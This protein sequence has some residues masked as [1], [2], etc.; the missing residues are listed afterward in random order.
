MNETTEYPA[1]TVFSCAGKDAFTEYKNTPINP[2]ISL[3]GA[4]AI[5]TG[6]YENAPN[7]Q[8]LTQSEAELLMQT[9]KWI[10]PED[11]HDDVSESL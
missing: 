1:Y 8:F 3:D 10:A 6:I 2:R 4:Q 11:N 7:A 9:T 5:V